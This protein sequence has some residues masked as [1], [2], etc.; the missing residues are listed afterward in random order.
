MK[1]SATRAAAKKSKLR[2]GTQCRAFQKAG[3]QRGRGRIWGAK[4]GQ[5][6][7][8]TGDKVKCILKLSKDRFCWVYW[9]I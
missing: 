3:K 1:C 6:G 4:K 9:I 2:L 7:S 8:L 5:G